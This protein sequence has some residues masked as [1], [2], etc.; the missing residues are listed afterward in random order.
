MRLESPRIEPVSDADLND[1]QKEILSSLNEMARSMNLFRT[2]LVSPSAMKAQ[3]VWSNYVGSR[4][5]NEVPWR[6]KELIILRVSYLCKSGYEWSHHRRLGA[7]AGLTEAEIL[8]AKDA[9]GD[10]QWSRQDQT[11]INMCDELVGNFCVANQTWAELCED[12]SVKQRMDLVY[13]ASHY[14]MVSMFANSFGIQPDEGVPV[15]DELYG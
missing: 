3:M 9:E 2:S 8:A 1:D 11:L 12:F 13:T 15:D 5:T 4:K 6:E 10:H 14:T 7:L